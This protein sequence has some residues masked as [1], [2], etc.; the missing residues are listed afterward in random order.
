MTKEGLNEMT[1]SPEIVR[2][3]SVVLLGRLQDF[4]IGNPNGIPSDL[5]E[6]DN[7]ELQ[8]YGERLVGALDYVTDENHDGCIDGRRVKHNADGSLAEVRHRQVSGTG[9]LVEE[10]RNGG[11]PIV[12]AVAPDESL[13]DEV[14]RYEQ[15]YD[16]TH[17]VKPS[18]H[19][20]ICG[21]VGGAIGDNESIHSNPAIL[22]VSSAIIQQPVI[23]NF[24]HIEYNSSASDRVRENANDT[25]EHLRSHGWEGERYVDGTQRRNPSGVEVLEHAED[26]HHGHKENAIV[27][28]LSE[29]RSISEERLEELNLGDV[30]V[31][32][33]KRSRDK[34]NAFAGQRGQAGAEQ[35][36][37][38]NIAKHIAVADRLPGDKTPVYII[39][40]Y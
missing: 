35:Y 19:T 9:S 4:G 8:A 40:D 20:A 29:D 7:A 38:A 31:I 26:N 1:T 3:T 17:G 28:V 14:K 36:L 33:M 27:I 15:F 24:T 12:D 37:I 23:L 21:G 34:A 16:D 18:A 25:A 5:A 32:S 30:F 22:D 6:S 13:G 2:E 11:S 10:V 39:K